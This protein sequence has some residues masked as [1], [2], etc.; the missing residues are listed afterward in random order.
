METTNTQQPKRPMGMTILL[1]LSFLNA[2]L[3]IF[4][5][6]I[7]FF[8]TPML[9]EMMKNGQF[10]DAMAPFLSTANEEMRTAMM[11]SMATL[12][13]IKPVYYLF[14]LVLFV[15]SLIGVIRMFK[16]DKRGFHIYSIS[17]LLMLIAASVYKYPLMQPSPFMTDMLLTAM[18]ILVYYLYIKRLELANRP[19]TNNDSPNPFEG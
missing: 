7:M 9:A 17:Q 3:N 10:E 5:S 4:S 15:G 14:M 2:V 12:S 8:G 16:L 19:N 13:N 11:D 6:I 18:F 1:V